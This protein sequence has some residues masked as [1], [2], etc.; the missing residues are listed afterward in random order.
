M[1]KDVPMPFF[2]FPNRRGWFRW[3]LL[4]ISVSVLLVTVAG[5]WVAVM[6]LSHAIVGT[7]RMARAIV[8]RGITPRSLGLQADEF[9]VEVDPG[10]CLKGWFVPALGPAKGTVLMLHGHDSCK[11][12]MLR[13][14]SVWVRN[15]YNILVYDSRGCGESGGEYCT[16]GF[17]E[18]RDCSRCLD[19]LQ[20]RYG[21]ALGPV[22]VYG[23][24]FGGAVALQTMA[25]DS[26]IRCGIVESTFATLREVV[27]DNEH[28]WFH[29]SAD[30]LADAALNRAGE[31]AKFPPDAVRPE[32]SAEQ[33][34]RP[35]LLIHGT[36]DRTVSFEYS[37]RIR[38]RL[39]V[40]GCELY[41]VEGATHDNLWQVGGEAY[42]QH[43]TH[44][45]EAYDH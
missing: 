29:V 39:H 10:I 15:G 42:R 40:S 13:L 44:F 33:I 20:R 37:E 14:G 28:E 38:R 21:A 25:E 1:V 17:Y 31:V 4:F 35:V 8:Y 7:N 41:P 2:T 6:V 3:G 23:N 16:F 34:R 12:S 43:T 24:S 30:G 5:R 45:L 11:E 27:R 32:T 36:K 19:A 18:R 22:A 26:R 9:G